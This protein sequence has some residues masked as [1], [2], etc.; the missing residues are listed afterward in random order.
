MFE[1]IT[2]LITSPRFCFVDCPVSNPLAHPMS[3][4]RSSTKSK[5]KDAKDTQMAKTSGK[6]KKDIA[7]LQAAHQE[8]MRALGGGPGPVNQ[9]GR[10]PHSMLL[11]SDSFAEPGGVLTL[12]V[13][14][15]SSGPGLVPGS[16]STGLYSLQ[17]GQN[18]SGIGQVGGSNPRTLQRRLTIDEIALNMSTTSRHDSDKVR[19]FV[20]LSIKS[21]ATA[22]PGGVH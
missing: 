3:L 13:A 6:G 10:N 20:C 22:S 12:G 15:P 14:L 8:R 19:P 21:H 9:Q 17:P 18:I 11:K 7:Q 2:I 5:D 4:F 1:R 16:S